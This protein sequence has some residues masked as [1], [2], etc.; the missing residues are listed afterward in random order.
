MTPNQQN[1]NDKTISTDFTD[2]KPVRSQREPLNLLPFEGV[3]N[4]IVQAYKEELPSK[5]TK[6]GKQWVLQVI[7]SP[8]THFKK[9]DGTEIP[10]IP[11]ETFWLEESP[12]GKI[13]GYSENGK[14]AKMLLR[15]NCQTP[16][17]LIGKTVNLHV[18]VTKNKTGDEVQHFIKFTY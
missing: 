1:L 18:I 16:V 5:F 17:D 12:E 3:K 9:N 15:Y 6:R 8:V 11:K 7:G 2:L 10:I 14:L 4:V 13:I